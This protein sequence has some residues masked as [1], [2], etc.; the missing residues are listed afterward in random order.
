MTNECNSVHIAL[1]AILLLLYA[2][3]S[4]PIPG[5]DISRSLLVAIGR[6]V[7]FPI[8]FPPTSIGNSRLLLQVWNHIHETLPHAFLPFVKSPTFL[9]K[10]TEPTIVSS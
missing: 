6:E 7:A 4:C 10:N 2:W 5:T 9:S 3:N 1:E 8:G